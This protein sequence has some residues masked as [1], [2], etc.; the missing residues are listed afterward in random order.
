MTTRQGK[1]SKGSEGGGEEHIHT[2][3][4][5]YTH[6]RTDTQTHTHTLTHTH[7]HT[8]THS[9]ALTSSLTFSPS[10][11]CVPPSSSLR[12]AS[13]PAMA[14]EGVALLMRGDELTQHTKEEAARK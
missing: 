2:H 8:Q 6:A 7:T 5:T 12:A 10:S 1:R 3:M 13:H 14:E 9:T 11:A 4:L